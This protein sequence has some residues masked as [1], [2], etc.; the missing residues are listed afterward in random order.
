MRA[1]HLWEAEECTPLTFYIYA[2][3]L[4]M[5]EVPRKLVEEYLL[6][7]VALTVL[8]AQLGPSVLSS[9]AAAL[10]VAGCAAQFPSL[11]C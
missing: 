8:V 5:L 7:G 6:A 10:C 9:T 4:Q 11:W 1:V 3:N 2:L